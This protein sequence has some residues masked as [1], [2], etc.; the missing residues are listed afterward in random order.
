MHAPLR[1]HGGSRLDRDLDGLI[2]D[3]GAAI[4]DAAWNPI[5]DA[6]MSP[7]LGPQLDELNSLF[8]RWDAPSKPTGDGMFDGWYQYFER[9]IRGL[10]ELPIESPFQNSYCGNGNL[11]AC[12]QSIWA[13]LQT[14]GEQLAAEQGPDPAAWRD[15]AIPERITFTPGLLPFTMRYTNRPTGIQQVISFSGHG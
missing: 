10:L 7:V 9:D 6:M 1:E 5:A 4:M 12:Q 14:A 11:K 2:D 3:P 8:N 13:A 15:S